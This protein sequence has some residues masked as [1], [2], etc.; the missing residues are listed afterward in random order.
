M[1]RRVNGVPVTVG[2]L[3][4][5][6][7]GRSERTAT[8]RQR[9]LVGAV[10]DPPC[11]G[12]GNCS[13]RRRSA[14]STTTTDFGAMRHTSAWHWPNPITQTY[15]TPE[16]S[17]SAKPATRDDWAHGSRSP[18]TP[19]AGRSAHPGTQWVTFSSLPLAGMV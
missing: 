6:S 18:A 12:A 16:S 3:Y 15:C 8:M 17:G 4:R 2:N 1:I 14:M 11:D 7:R 9:F 10:G 19:S 5:F 13:A